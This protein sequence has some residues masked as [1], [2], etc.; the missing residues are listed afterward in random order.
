MKKQFLR[1]PFFIF[2]R[3]KQAREFGSNFRDMFDRCFTSDADKIA[4]LNPTWLLGTFLSPLT[5]TTT[6]PPPTSCR[7][8]AAPNAARS[9][10]CAARASRLW[11][12][13]FSAA[14]LSSCFVNF[15]LLRDFFAN[16]FENP[17]SC[18]LILHA[19]LHL[20]IVCSA[21]V[22]FLSSPTERQTELH[23]ASFEGGGG[24]D[25]GGDAGGGDAGGGDA[26]GGDAGGGGGGDDGGGGA[27]EFISV[28][29]GTR[30]GARSHSYARAYAS[31]STRHR[32]TDTV[33]EV[34]VVKY[35]M[36]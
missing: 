14:G 16:G 1:Q 19:V 15:F 30:T 23:A 3:H 25:A 33:T 34:R 31:T 17:I 11:Y 4:T 2:H 28:G 13:C 27:A 36:R 8:F 32:M 35:E 24:G 21:A 7:A 12:G 20:F 18:C 26:G 6:R 9:M 29:S 22:F 10:R 5:L